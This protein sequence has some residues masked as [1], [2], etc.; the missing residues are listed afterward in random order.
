MYAQGSLVS[1]GYRN[2]LLSLGETLPELSAVRLLFCSFFSVF[3]TRSLSIVP[4]VS[5]GKQKATNSHLYK[6]CSSQNL[7]DN[8]TGGETRLAERAEESWC[9]PGHHRRG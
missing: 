1:H 2:A 9:C 3:T 8:G 5:Q 6:P 7:T 4:F